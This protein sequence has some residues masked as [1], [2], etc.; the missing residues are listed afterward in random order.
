MDREQLWTGVLSLINCV[1]YYD[2]TQAVCV[3][4]EETLHIRK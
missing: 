1:S 3:G 4:V 2:M